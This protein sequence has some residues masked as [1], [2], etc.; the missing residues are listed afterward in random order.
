LNDYSKLWWGKWHPSRYHV[1]NSSGEPC[2]VGILYQNTPHDAAFN[3]WLWQFDF[4]TPEQMQKVPVAK[5][6]KVWF[7]SLR[8]IWDMHAGT[9]IGVATLGMTPDKFARYIRG[10]PAL[11]TKHGP[12]L[13]V[14]LA[15]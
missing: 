9:E 13:E 1:E 8:L 7:D 2:G 15:G 14:Q 3:L 5:Q 4:K 11:L 12:K 10:G 6:M